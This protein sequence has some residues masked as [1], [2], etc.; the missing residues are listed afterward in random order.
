[1]KTAQFLKTA[2][3][4][5][6]IAC[7]SATAALAQS[8]V[9][10]P[11]A[12]PEE[13]DSSWSGSLSGTI[14]VSTGNSSNTN[15]GLFGNAAKESGLY[16]HLLDGGYLF[17]EADGSTAQSKGFASYQLNRSFAD[18]ALGLND[19]FY[20]FG[21]VSGI[22]D[23]FGAFRDDYFAGAGVGYKAID[24]AATTWTLD[25]AAGLRYLGEPGS[26]IEPALRFASRYSHNVNERVTFSNDTS[27]LF[28]PEDTLFVNDTALTAQLT[29]TLSAR[30]GFRIDHHTN[31]P[32]GTEPTD[33][34]TYAGV[35]Y[36]F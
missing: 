17:S 20:A 33:T 12:A 23:E 36:G 8:V 22:Y 27:I 18:G 16:T 25:T 7:L 13:I 15:V 34:L 35:T 31:A 32:D 11:R 4:A 19:R 10:G 3:A 28:S 6:A 2:A 5:A 30:A 26:N 9:D 1:M 24:T 29:E 14:S 21:I